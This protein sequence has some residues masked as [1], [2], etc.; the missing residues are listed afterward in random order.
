M[1][2]LMRNP[3]TGEIR[4]VKVGF[5]WILLL[6]S[7]FFGL[8]LF[9]RKL[10]VFGNLFLAFIF[11]IFITGFI[12]GFKGIDI[13]T[14][15]PFVLFVQFI[16]IGLSVFLGIKGNEITAKNYLE[17]GWEFVDNNSELV[18]YAQR[19]WNINI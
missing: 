6:F 3:K 11:I 18:Q 15:E 8:P 5:S 12:A 14:I 16:I 1:V 17:L 9:F 7:Q 10:V 4:G 19:K 13:E 2:V